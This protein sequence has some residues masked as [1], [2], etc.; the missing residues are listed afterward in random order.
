MS[1]YPNHYIMKSETLNMW[2]SLL[3]FFLP[4]YGFL[5]IS[6]FLVQVLMVALLYSIVKF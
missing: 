5:N 4:I 2:M 6:Y 1:F 3:Y